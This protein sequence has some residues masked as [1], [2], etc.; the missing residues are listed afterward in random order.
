VKRTA[1]QSRAS[2]LSPAA[3]LTDYKSFCLI[4]AV[5]CWVTSIL[6]LGVLP[7]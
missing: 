7:T 2:D 6:P 3:R 4:P 5:K 1:E